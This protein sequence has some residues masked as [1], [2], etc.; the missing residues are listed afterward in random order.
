MLLLR[1]AAKL[2][3]HNN[4]QCNT[5]ACFSENALDDPINIKQKILSLI[6]ES[7]PLEKKLKK[8]FDIKTANTD[9]IKCV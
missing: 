9:K 4:Y 5:L 1:L 3:P 2:G 6:S 7:Y 8:C